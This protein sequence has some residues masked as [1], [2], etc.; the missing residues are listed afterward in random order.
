M[1]EN[2][3]YDQKKRKLF[4]VC[5]L[6]IT[7][8]FFSPRDGVKEKK[9]NSLMYIT[10]KQVCKGNLKP[11][12]LRMNLVAPGNTYCR[13]LLPLPLEDFLYQGSLCHCVLSWKMYTEWHCSWPTFSFLNIFLHSVVS[14]PH[15]TA[16]WAGQRTHRNPFS[17][18]LGYNMS[19]SN[20]DTLALH[21]EI[22]LW[23]PLCL[24]IG[25]INPWKKHPKHKL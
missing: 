21:Q 25:L 8:L 9:N 15:S 19:N 23:G 24:H 16:V 4:P 13:Q 3:M 2:Q 14:F 17:S 10:Y 18:H 11:Q 5:S 12:P 20:T 6:E 1:T 7:W 22:Q